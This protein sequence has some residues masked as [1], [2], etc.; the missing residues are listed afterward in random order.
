MNNKTAEAIGMLRGI[1]YGASQAIAE[2]IIDAVEMLEDA[3]KPEEE[4]NTA[5]N[6]LSGFHV[7][8]IHCK[9]GFYEAEPN[10]V[11]CQK[12]LEGVSIE[13]NPHAYCSFAE[14]EKDDN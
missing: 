6:I 8:C 3:L 11:Y 7:K 14:R 2:G 4:R 9:H 12:L 5:M 13:M 10:I 1:S